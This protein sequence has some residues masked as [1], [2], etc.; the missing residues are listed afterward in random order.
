VVLREGVALDQGGVDVTRVF[1]R[2]T[3]VSSTVSDPSI[4]RPQSVSLCMYLPRL[5]TRA[6]GYTTSEHP[7]DLFAAHS[8]PVD[9][10]GV[11]TCA[12]LCVQ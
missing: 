7:G 8:F 12:R 10:C 6:G 9:S 11:C 5:E 2:L 4:W 3:S 1:T